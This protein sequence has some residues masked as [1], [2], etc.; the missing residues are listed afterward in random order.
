M[1]LQDV[2]AALREIVVGLEPEALAAD[3][4]AG[5]VD[6]FAT[7]EKLAGAGKALAA[8]RVGDSHPWRGA[9]ERFAAHWLARRAGAPVGGGLAPLL[10]ALRLPGLAA[11]GGAVARWGA[12]R[13][14]W[15]W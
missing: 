4:A 3:A 1:R 9:G 15:N 13:G 7:I 6:T 5:L 8:R 12:P 14:P 10:T 2:E 11:P